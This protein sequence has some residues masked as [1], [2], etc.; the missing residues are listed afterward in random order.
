M[1]CGWR[2]TLTS[3]IAVV[4]SGN[5]VRA[6]SREC[7]APFPITVLLGAANIDPAIPAMLRG[8]GIETCGELAA[9][10]QEAIEV[11]LGADGVRL[12]RLARAEDRWRPPPSLPR[13]LP[14]ASLEWTD[15]A[16]RDVERM[17]F[18]IH[19][20]LGSVC[21]ALRAR[22]EGARR[23]TLSFALDNRSTYEHALGAARA[24]ASRVSWMRLIRASLESVHVPD[25]V[26]GITLRADEVG[27]VHGRQGDVFDR[28]FAT[29]SAAE[30]A[31]AQLLDAR[32]GDIVT[33][34][35]TDHPLP[36]RR[37]VWQVRKS[38]SVGAVCDNDPAARS[39][40]T[41]QWAPSLTLQ[42]L[43]T[44]HAA[45][46]TTAR[47]RDH[48]YPIRYTDVTAQAGVPVDIVSAAGP[49]DISGGQWEGVPYTRSY[50][51]CVTAD[52]HLVLLFRDA[53]DAWYLH[54]WWD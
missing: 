7:L 21:D 23:L 35:T 53:D 46:V 27:A 16:L 45:A 14:C 38:V 22:G 39:A 20:L 47:R 19:G 12:W 9:L 13:T 34:A 51:H 18:V 1:T 48:A 10:D 26:T 3:S 54:G 42:L 30:S 5:D 17:L 4:S 36:E 52:G 29:A 6:H 15:Y 50:F 49:D 8:V 31:V 25:A 2:W 28:G 11:R 32:L 24:T 33:L 43:P 37:G 41:I 40:T 44:P